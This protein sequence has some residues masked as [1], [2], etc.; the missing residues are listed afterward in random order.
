MRQGH[1]PQFESFIKQNAN[2][3]TASEDELRAELELRNFKKPFPLH[4]FNDKIKPFLDA[5][6]NEY[7]LP[8]SFIGLTLLAAYSAA[9][10]TC[11]HLRVKK[12]GNI[13]LPIWACLE[14][15][16][17]SGK[18][19]V[20]N[21]V[22]KPL[23]EK[24]VQ[25]DEEAEE[26]KNITGQ[27][28]DKLKQLV[29]RDSHVQTL[30]RSVM[31]DNPKGI[32]KDADEILEWINGMNQISRKEGTDEQF[33]MSGWNCRPY[34][35]IRANQQKYHLAS[36][37][38]NVIGGVQ[39]SITYKLFKNDRETTG[40]IFRLLFAVPEVVKIADVNLDYEM[41][42]EFEKIHRE[43][44]NSLIDDLIATSPKASDYSKVLELSDEAIKEYKGWVVKRRNLT[45]R[46]S[47]PKEKEIHAGIL[48]KI[49]EY[50][51]RFS[52]ILHIADLS[53]DEHPV[54]PNHDFIKR[55]TVL[56][57]IE[58]AEYFFESAVN[59]SE[60]VSK[61]VVAPPEVIRFASYTHAAFS[62]QKIGDLEFNT[63][64][65]TPEARKK[66]AERAIKKMI[67]EYPNVFRAIEK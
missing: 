61:S 57:A 47:D 48:G 49:K 65:S 16:S 44:I 50:C 36:P 17:S 12:I 30:I 28:P 63:K 59:V 38:V 5:L 66:K 31:T 62:F 13:Y 64:G 15:I 58:L 55:S 45:N 6:H 7:D 4:V 60:R 33:W 67:K 39:P 23:N 22:L 24:Q 42:D 19:L 9:I 18:S 52:A 25:F 3:A 26:C 54:Y 8:R 21:Q 11:Y 1:Y 41:P 46:I 20:M 37:F 27:Y 40:F 53:Y 32:L 2:L 43:S 10:G 34:T 56:R 29:Y 14:G 51:L 35:A